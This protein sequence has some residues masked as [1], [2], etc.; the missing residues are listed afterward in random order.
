MFASCFFVWLLFFIR[1]AWLLKDVGPF[2]WKNNNKLFAKEK[3][4]ESKV[5]QI[6]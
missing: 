5:L 2:F 3:D 4:C 1:N 6:D